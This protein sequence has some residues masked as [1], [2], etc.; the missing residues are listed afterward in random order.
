MKIEFIKEI[1]IPKKSQSEVILEMKGPNQSNEKLSGSL[2][3]RTDSVDDRIPGFGRRG[4]GSG[5]LA[6]VSD[7]F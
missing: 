2:I 1:E 7:K 6:K 5:S 3:N 4:S